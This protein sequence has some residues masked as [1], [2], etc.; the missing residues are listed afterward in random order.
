MIFGSFS[1]KE[2]FK[3]P[4]RQVGV[5]RQVLTKKGQKVGQVLVL[6]MQEVVR[7]LIVI[8]KELL[9]AI[10]WYAALSGTCVYSGRNFA[11]LEFREM[12][13]LEPKI[14]R[15]SRNSQSIENT[16]LAR[17]NMQILGWNCKAWSRKQTFWIKFK[18]KSKTFLNFTSK[19]MSVFT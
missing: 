4:K 15:N 17:T 14:L 5:G 10:S 3:M 6:T 13:D 18:Y 12:R 8:Q 2:I 11:L 7:S 9:C 16:Q 19:I 1:I